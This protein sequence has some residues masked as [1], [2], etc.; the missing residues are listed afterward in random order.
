[1]HPGILLVVRLASQ[2]CALPQQQR[3]CCGCGGNHTANYR[4]C[5]N[6]TKGKAALAMRTPVTLSKGGA[7]N[8]PAAP[9]AKRTEPFAKQESL[10]P[11][12]NH[13]VR[14]GR[15]VSATPHADPHSRPGHR[16]EVTNT[17]KKGN[18][19]KSASEVTVGPKDTSVTNPKKPSKRGK[20]RQFKP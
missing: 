19:A 17:S 12:W 13:V 11:R 20:L 7:P 2:G 8:P 14:G 3:K 15:F 10:G 18:T 9:K 1:M 16:S 6:W 5:V 4:G